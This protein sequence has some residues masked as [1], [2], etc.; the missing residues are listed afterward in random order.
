MVISSR[1]TLVHIPS[2]HQV[3][4]V[5]FQGPASASNLGG[6]ADHRVDLQDSLCLSAA[7]S[8]SQLPAEAVVGEGDSSG[9]DPRLAKGALILSTPP[10]QGSTPSAGKIKSSPKSHTSS[11]QQ[12]QAVGLVVGLEGSQPCECK[13]AECSKRQSARQLSVCQYICLWLITV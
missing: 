6:G 2:Q 7:F 13:Q 12:A 3:A 1:G 10:N 5:L 11:T 9:D 4:K 8:D